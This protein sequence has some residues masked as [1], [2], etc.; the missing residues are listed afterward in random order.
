MPYFA[1]AYCGARALPR[2]ITVEPMFTIAPWPWSSIRDPNSWVQAI[3]PLMSTASTWSTDSSVMSRHD[4]CSRATSPTLLI[5]ASTVPSSA[6][7]S[8]ANAATLATTRCRPGTA[9]PPPPGA[10]PLGG[11]LRARARRAVVDAD[12]RGTLLGGADRDRGAEAGAGSGHEHGAALEAAR[13]GQ[14]VRMG[15]PITLVPAYA[16]GEGGCWLMLAIR[17]SDAAAPSAGVQ[18]GGCTCA[19]ARERRVDARRSGTMS[20]PERPQR[21]AGSA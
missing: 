10:H 11:L 20:L 14:G 13:R 6:K 18:A 17:A 1:A 7:T 9:A 21:H 2:T 4:I 16:V 19:R 3:V 5:T 12:R 8:S 15:H